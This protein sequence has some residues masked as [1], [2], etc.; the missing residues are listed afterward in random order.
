M[1]TASFRPPSRRR[2]MDVRALIEQGTVST[3]G[4]STTATASANNS[5]SDA[6]PS[7]TSA[8][9]SAELRK[10]LPSSP[11]FAFQP[12]LRTVPA[13][14]GFKRDQQTSFTA[15]STA[16]PSASSSFEELSSAALHA[17]SGA[18]Q[19]RLSTDSVVTVVVHPETGAGKKPLPSPGAKTGGAGAS[20]MTTRPPTAPT[21][22]GGTPSAAGR[23][24]AVEHQSKLAPP[25]TAPQSAGFRSSSRRRS[26]H[27]VLQVQQSTTHHLAEPLM[28][29]RRGERERMAEIERLESMKPKPP[30][31]PMVP[32]LV[33]HSL[34][35]TSQLAVAKF[36]DTLGYI[37]ECVQQGPEGVRTLT[38]VGGVC[39][40]LYYGVS[41]LNFFALLTNPFR[42]FMEAS[43]LV[44]GG[45]TVIWEASDDVL[46]DWR[47]LREY[48]AWIA[49]YVKCLAI[50]WCLG[51][52]YFYVGS[53]QVMLCRG[54]VSLDMLLGLYFCLMG[55]FNLSLHYGWD[56]EK[57]TAAVGNCIRS[58]AGWLRQKIR[59][60]SAPANDEPVYAAI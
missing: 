50:P 43:F 44:F 26:M 23:G 45:I 28:G 39:M 14:E 1:T 2:T 32:A 59:E 55:A 42:Y 53:L 12:G 16:A 13:A 54:Y 36:G 41:L 17:V 30:A 9:S 49:E 29:S 3:S 8:T 35:S 56:I 4:S 5:S 22:N 46:A 40:C 31:S 27:E 38:F 57:P 10:K 18:A 52:F 25:T 6:E 19:S 60:F 51:V 24:N 34:Q 21:S 7:I 37:Q 11:A 33:A 20:N 58:S 48:Q 47:V 15:T